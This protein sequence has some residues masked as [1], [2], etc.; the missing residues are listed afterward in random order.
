MDRRVALKVLPAGV[1]ADDKA[2][3]RFVQEAR[4]RGN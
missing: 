4:A 3:T 2:V 1:A